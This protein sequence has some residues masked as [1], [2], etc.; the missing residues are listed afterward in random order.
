MIIHYN[1]MSRGMNLHLPAILRCSPGYQ[2]FGP[3]QKKIEHSVEHLICQVANSKQSTF[4]LEH[5]IF[6]QTDPKILKL[7]LN[8]I[9][10]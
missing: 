8:E 6:R 4:F 3:S 9:E 2:G 10:I 5:P 7:K 1:T